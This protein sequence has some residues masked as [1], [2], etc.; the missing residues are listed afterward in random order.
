MIEDSVKENETVTLLKSIPG[1]GSIT[2]AS[3]IFEIEDP[4]RFQSSRT[5]AAYLGLT[6]RLY[7]SGEIHIMGR[8][9]KQGSS[10]LRSLLYQAG[11]LI[12][13]RCTKWSKL[14]AWGM[15]IAQR[16]GTKKASIAIARKLAFIMHRMLITKEKFIFGESK[17]KK[18][19]KK[20]SIPSKTKLI[21]EE[22]VA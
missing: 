17:I 16:H 13:T 19:T 7:E 14:K 1:V 12:L 8:I 11:H 21:K 10:S 6:P 22:A 15:K 18:E 2:A 20:G 4:L 5:V 3:F 9:S